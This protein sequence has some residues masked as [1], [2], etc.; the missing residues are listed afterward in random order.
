VA[1][2]A[3]DEYTT[4]D[5]AVD[6]LEG[7]GADD[8]R[9]LDLLARNRAW[10]LRQKG[11]PDVLNTAI[12][13]ILSGTRRWPRQ[14]PLVAFVAQTMRS[15]ADEFRQQEGRDKVVV[16][17]DLLGG[18][19]EPGT[20]IFQRVASD[21]ATPEQ[22]LIA[23][24]TLA[25]IEGLFAGDEEGLGIVMARAEGYSPAECHEMLDLTPTQYD[26]ALKRVRRKLLRSNARD[27]DL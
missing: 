5:E 18:V 10:G 26:T 23:K 3:I 8:H 16:E 2:P 21:V 24:E 25:R 13:R 1:K 6:A 17:S 19:D 22:E 12:E 14:V 27:H 9:R 20:S 4:P 7:L 11:W 15:V